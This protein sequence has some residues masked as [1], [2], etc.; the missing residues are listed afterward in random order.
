MFNNNR[1]R[2]AWKTIDIMPVVMVWF[3]VRDFVCFNTRSSVSR[4]LKTEKNR[5]SLLS[6][7]NGLGALRSL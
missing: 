1:K 4:N 5:S 7:L 3:E 2:G 6:P